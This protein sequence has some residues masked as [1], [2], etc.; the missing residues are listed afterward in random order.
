MPV[1]VG[2][3][4]L[5]TPLRVGESVRVTPPTA[6]TSPMLSLLAAMLL[7]Q[8]TP[9]SLLTSSAGAIQ[10]V[11]NA[12]VVPEAG[13]WRISFSPSQWPNAGYAY[14]TPQDWTGA[15]G[16]RVTVTNP[17]HATVKFNIRID[18][19]SEA[20][21]IDHCRT[22]SGE[23][24]AGATTTF[25]SAIEDT[26]MKHGMRG[27]PRSQ[28]RNGLDLGGSTLDLHH[29]VRWQIFLEDPKQPTELIFKDLSLDR[30]TT[31]LNNI[32]DAFGQYSGTDW[33]Q[34]VHNAR[35][36]KEDGDR[37]QTT[38]PGFGRGYD[39]YG[40]WLA[41]PTLRASGRFRTEKLNGK[42]WLITPVGHLF[43]SLGVDAVR[44][45]DT[46]IITGREDLF[47]SLPG[48]DDPLAQCFHT[49]SWT[50]MGP[51][52]GKESKTFDFGTAN[53]IRKYGSDWQSRFVDDTLAKLAGW[54][55][56]TIGNW[57]SDDFRRRGKMPYVGTANVRGEYAK[58][59]SGS[60]YWGPMP[61]VFDP[62][63]AAAGADSV[64]QQVESFKSDPMCLG[65]FVD[66]ELS[67][68]GQGEDGGRYGIAYGA[69]RAP[70]ES[71]AKQEFIRQLK[72]RY[73][74]VDSLNGAWHTTFASWDDLQKPT[75]FTSENAES[76]KE[77]LHRFTLSFA[78]KYFQVVSSAVKSADPDALY[79]GCRFAW[80]GPEAE[81]AGAEYADVVS[82]NIYAKTIDSPKWKEVAKLNKPC[83]I[84][85]FHF[86]ATDR[87]MFHPGLV[88]AGSQQGRGEMYQTFVKSVI[89]NPAFVGCHW[90]EFRDEPL[91]GRSLDGENYN[92]GLVDVVD[93]AYPELTKA[94]SL[95]HSRVYRT[96]QG[97]L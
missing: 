72:E 81:Q 89:N 80:Y 20:D 28:N 73:T 49:E 84:G 6:Y 51:Q 70:A 59:Y 96:K 56:N 30:S 25:A 17:G 23:V 11:S 87:G 7:H 50:L 88:N 15:P 79:L 71:P 76:R 37:A 45:G 92:I 78:R 12:K 66:N 54:G 58:V 31:D 53:L 21:G 65:W 40:G 38:F 2:P 1:R 57:S 77:D 10:V 27:L 94:A 97:S 69:L 14:A 39:A 83:I 36:L 34:K 41:G 33:R 55:F 16:L 43:F 61:D 13:G 26:A 48:A 90:F 9:V 35:D 67:W 62:Q 63:F 75:K 85:E 52:K 29:I 74:T 32:V 3:D 86:G 64:R 44:P 5:I 47:S 4:S 93:R 8:G 18:D 22:A 91:T 19:S 95:V 82:Y 24:Q 46:T 60:D 68:S 42:W